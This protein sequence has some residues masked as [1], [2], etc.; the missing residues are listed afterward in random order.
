MNSQT[1]YERFART[2]PLRLFFLAAVPGAVSMLASALYQVIDG[3]FV[4]QFLGETAFAAL[5]LAMPFV[6]INFSLADLVGVGSSVPISIDLGRREERS[7][8]NIFTCACILIVASSAAIGAVLFAAAPPLMAL[9]GAEGEFAAL[10]VQYLQVYALCSPGTTIV[11]AVDNYLR[12]CGKVRRSMFLNIFM[13]VVSGV[14]E[15]LFLA[16]FRWGIWAAA[17]AT[18]LGMFLSALVAF[19]PFFRQTMPLRFCRPR[20]S[21]RMIGKIVS[22]GAPN[23]LNNIAGRIT[24]ILMNFL[25]V[26]L[27]GES[28]VSIYGILMYAEGFIQPLLYGMC[29][30]LQP[31]VGYN[32]GAG[33]FSRVRAIERCCFSASALLSVLSA[34][35][36]YAFPQQIGALFVRD[37]SAAFMAETAAALRLFSF[38]YLTRW[39]SFAAQSYM[40]AIERAAAASLISV[41][42]A[43]VFP[44]LLVAVLWPLGLTGL[45]LNFAGTSLLAGILAAAVL[46]VSLKKLPRGPDL[47]TP[48][49]PAAPERGE[50]A[51]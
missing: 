46:R 33:K 48:G 29:D 39:F 25:L 24:S 45:W 36:I 1:L 19:Y 37:G 41:S 7:A 49:D 18:S 35:V 16:V 10:A 2:P 21:R 3:I 23:F 15:F 20:F 32:L 31:A 50:T 40:L 12:I 43:L 22:N 38:T 44:V 28:A 26:R 51:V 17:L 14:L 9:M 34:A 6:I 5:N 8:N 13:S 27:G 4:G 30:S 42:T 47:E 11:F